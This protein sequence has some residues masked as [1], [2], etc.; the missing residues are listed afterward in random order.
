M[1]R[2]LQSLALLLYRC[3]D[4][5]LLLLELCIDACSY[6]L[7]QCLDL[8]ATF[9]RV[10]T[11]RP[12][13]RHRHQAPVLMRIFGGISKGYAFFFLCFCIW[14]LCPPLQMA[15]YS[16]SHFVTHSLTKLVLLIWAGFFLIPQQRIFR[17]PVTRFFFRQ[18]WFKDFGEAHRFIQSLSFILIFLII[19]SVWQGPPPGTG[20]ML[21]TL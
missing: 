9:G 16:I 6:M 5:L 13:P 12:P 19:F 21:G 20:G 11:R 8:I 17:D 7:H 10:V 2:F 4:S 15:S 3:F 1:K 14:F 18:G